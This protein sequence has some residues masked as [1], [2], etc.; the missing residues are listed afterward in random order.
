M[1]TT[2]NG[3]KL[4]GLAIV[5]QAGTIERINAETYRVKSQSGNG[6]YQVSK[7]D[8]EWR[9]ECPDYARRGVVCKHCYAVACSITLR[10]KATSQ[11]FPPRVEL[12]QLSSLSCKRG[13]PEIVID[14]LRANKAGKLQRFTC[15]VC[16]YRFVVHEGFLKMKNDGKIVCLALDLYFKG[17]SFREIADTLSQFYNV[18]VE[19]STVIRWLQKYVRIAKAFVD[20]L[21]PELSGI[22]HVDEIV[23]RVRKT[24][25]MKIANKCGVQNENYAWLWNLADH[26][27]RFL[28]ASRVSKK[29]E[30][31]DA[32]AV[33]QDAKKL[34]VKRPLAVV[35]DGLHTYN[36]AFN[37]EFYTN[38]GPR[39]ENVRSVGQRDEGLNQMVERVNN[40][41]RDRE[42]TFRG[43]DNDRSAQIMAD[44]IRI[45][46]NFIRPHM[47][48]DG[49]TPAQTAGL[50]L[51]LDGI[52]WKELI[53]KATQAQPRTS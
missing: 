24:E 23:V 19:H 6:W 1:N 34:M 31:N 13:S 33:F 7:E 51:G 29:R 2:D 44:G 32:R 17:N 39:I 52:R 16:G 9:C 37:R 28:L 41:V 30:A 35:H 50:D 27:T 53:R 12:P 21:K 3:R 5:A 20:D 45:N 10:D 49:R 47:G 4:R 15:K 18:N 48:L 40:T 36:E 38:A 8:G 22:Y 11:N 26:N 42:K 14:G 25:P 43:M 46:Y